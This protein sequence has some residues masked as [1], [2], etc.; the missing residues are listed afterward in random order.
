MSYHRLKQECKCG[1]DTYHIQLLRDGN[2]TAIVASCVECGRITGSL[3]D[4]DFCCM[5]IGVL[6]E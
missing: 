1:N 5:D 3:G 6:T 4:K 2:H